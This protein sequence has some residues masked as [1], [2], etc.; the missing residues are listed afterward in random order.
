MRVVLYAVAVVFLLAGIVPVGVAALGH[1]VSWQGIILGML[2]GIGVA[3]FVFVLAGQYEGRP[4]SAVRARLP[5][6]L[7]LYLVGAAFLIPGL[8]LIVAGRMGGPSALSIASDD[9]ALSLLR[10]WD[11]AKGLVLVAA[12][13]CA[14]IA[15]VCYGRGPAP[16]QT[17]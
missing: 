10:L 1:G 5:F 2:P 15:A 8:C 7:L 14:L 4:R 13:I 9:A 16:S 6:Q 17:G 3:V 11:L 12:G